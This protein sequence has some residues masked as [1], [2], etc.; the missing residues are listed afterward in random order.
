MILSDLVKISLSNLWR[1]KLRSF[2]TISGVLIGIATLV[3]MLSFG[4]GMQKNVREQF[5]SF[6]LFST[7]QI[8]P[9]SP[10]EETESDSL[11]RKFLDDETIAEIEKLPGVKSVYPEDIFPV[12]V[13]FREKTVS[14]NA[15]SLPAS[16]KE[17][18]F[19]KK[20]KKGEF[21]ASDT[22][23]QVV[24]NMRLL[25]K[26]GS[27]EPDSI[28][29]EE[30]TV[31]SAKIDPISMMGA[32]W[33]RSKTPFKMSEYRFQVCG[34]RDMVND[35]GGFNLRELIIPYETARGIDRIGFNSA[36]ELLSKLSGEKR[37][38][39][40]S[41]TVRLHSVTDYD[42]THSKIEALGYNT[43]SFIEQFEEMKKVFLVFDL[44]LAIMGFIALVVA[45]LGILN[46]MVMSIVERYREIGI[47]KSLGADNGDIRLLYLVESGAIGFIGAVLG[48]V[49]GW[50]ITRVGS[51]IAGYYMQKQGVQFIEM[52]D[53]PWWLILFAL[54]FGT[55][56][57]LLAGL[58]PANRA[59]KIDP[60]RALR[61]E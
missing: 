52:F 50:V 33:G 58:Y 16:V 46:T 7:I 27:E 15:Q 32:F 61:N 53:L 4:A 51:F 47:L 40:P 11:P 22:A 17:L 30:I 10:K 49:F 13:R 26:L 38:K 1:M 59:A 42:S 6:D 12:R 9:H 39:Y 35:M 55:A 29:G 20:I 41:L 57:S 8:L 18:A 60:V 44:V 45:S 3:S 56:I 24:I 31:I 48:L 43:F 25:K 34:V 36:V 5:A 37:D 14:A 2:L 19:F 54:I 23:Q 28:L 21:F